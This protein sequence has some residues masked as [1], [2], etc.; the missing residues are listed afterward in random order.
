M[1]R[2]M[3]VA[4]SVLVAGAADDKHEL[5]IGGRSL[6]GWIATLKAKDSASR[7]TAA[8]AL[9]LLGPNAE[10][11]VPALTSALDDPGV[12]VP[13]AAM[14]ALGEFGPAAATAAP[15][16]ERK[17]AD[18]RFFYSS[19]APY[20]GSHRAA[21]AL[22]AIGPAAV[23]VLA[24]ALASDSEDTRG[25][26]AHA[27]G[28]IGPPAKSAVPALERVVKT[29]GPQ[30]GKP[31]VEA[32]GTIGP[33]AV[34]AAPTLHTAYDSLKADEDG[35]SL[36]EA[37]MKI[38]APPSPGLL[39]QLDDP[40]PQR[41]A[42]AAHLL[43]DFG[44]RARS[45]VPR[46]VTALG[47]P[48]PHVRVAAASALV[49]VDP[50][51]SRALP[52]LIIA[53]DSTDLEVL[54]TA[55]PAVGALGPKAAAATPKLKR[56]AGRDDLTH[57]SYVGLQLATMIGTVKST[58]A[59]ALV[60]VAPDSE[61]GVATLAALAGQKGE[62]RAEA[63]AALGRLGPR[64]LTA[65]PVLATVARNGKGVERLHAVKAL[66]LVDPDHGAILP[67]L[68]DLLSDPRLGSL[69]NEEGSEV[70]I[71]LGR[72]GPKALPAA[73]A[74]V[75]V[76]ED[77]REIEHQ[78]FGPAE[79]AANALGRIGPGTGVTIAP[80]ARALKT[81]QG[82]AEAAAGALASM[83]A[84]ARP[85]VGELT[86]LLKS[87]ETSGRAARVLGAIG[88]GAQ[89][90]VPSLVKAL[91]GKHLFDVEAVGTALLRI[92]R[93]TR[94][95]VEA[96]LAWIPG[97]AFHAR[98]V[99]SGALG[100]RTAEADGLTRRILRW[101]SDDLADLD[102]AMRTGDPVSEARLVAYEFVADTVQERLDSLA[103]LGVGATDALPEVSAASLI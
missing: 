95:V 21:D 38:G 7:I 40:D 87:G 74:L 36:L 46:L 73:P 103:V 5:T 102:R 89:S 23:P 61:E 58:S 91:D 66:A 14:V 51:N 19:G 79:E 4:W 16:L 53:L 20:S 75:R 65:A 24:E 1:V 50:T 42:D 49:Q 64:A 11:A 68:I 56:I 2:Q 69:D 77:K 82:I 34:A 47:D 59:E 71:R 99:L 52:A 18:R 97:S 25:W 44:L 15:A 27:L 83:G 76:L 22:A 85:A 32:L 30:E 90:A 26:A 45:A 8:S 101:L 3:V 13:I 57:Q 55:I 37:L 35:G 96:R 63:I 12:E 88:P 41:R 62:A 33:A 92:D 17:L 28:Q 100:R 43:S 80:L 81:E 6:A 78:P 31:S 72:M 9:A 48:S 86:A 94:P 70:I 67:A 54:V 60:A 84:A 10:A 98:A 39:Q 29:Y 93:S